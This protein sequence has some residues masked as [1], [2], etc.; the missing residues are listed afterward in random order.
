MLESLG[1]IANSSEEIT[2]SH[3][4]ITRSHGGISPYT[5]L[6]LSLKTSIYKKP[7]FSKD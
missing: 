1:G 6:F 4:G 2:N 7:V 3:G 5:N